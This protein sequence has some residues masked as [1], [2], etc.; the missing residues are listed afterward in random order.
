MRTPFEMENYTAT[1]EAVEESESDDK[2]N[3]HI[4]GPVGHGQDSIE[5]ISFP[6]EQRTEVARKLEAFVEKQTW[7]RAIQD[8]TKQELIEL[9]KRVLKKVKGTPEATAVGTETAAETASAVG[10]AETAAKTKEELEAEVAELEKLGTNRRGPMFPNAMPLIQAAKLEG[11]ER[12]G[13]DK[14]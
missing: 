7:Y 6:A 11:A 13:T 1:E 10:T 14:A 9:I 2:K 3:V 12:L 5:V 8:P 4:K